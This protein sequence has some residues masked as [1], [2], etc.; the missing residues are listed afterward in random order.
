[1][2]DYISAATKHQTLVGTTADRVM[3]TNSD[4]QYI[5]VFN[6]SSAGPLYV[7]FGVSNSASSI[8]GPNV[9]ADPVADADNTFF[10]PASSNRVF[11]LSQTRHTWPDIFQ[12]RG[13]GT[14]VV[15]A[16]VGSSNPYSVE[17]FTS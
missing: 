8:A 16:L 2:A 11:S 10:I 13:S 3:L 6:K 4:V 9:P 1:M 5:H 7:T 17:G 14:G 12:S 15:V